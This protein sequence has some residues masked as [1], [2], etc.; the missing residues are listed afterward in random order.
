[1]E[2]VVS[3]PA[4]CDGFIEMFHHQ[5][6]RDSL[7]GIL[8]PNAGWYWMMRLCVIGKPRV[9]PPSHWQDHAVKVLQ[10]A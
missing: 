3:S 5:L 7:F 4:S 8:P 10:V 2:P 6:L 1:M 9:K